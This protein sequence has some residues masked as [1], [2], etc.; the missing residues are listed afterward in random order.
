MATTLENIIIRDWYMDT[1]PNDDLGEDLYE[2][3]T[4][5][6]ALD[7]LENGENFYLFLGVCDSTVLERVFEKLSEL[8]GKGYN[9]IYNMWL[10]ERG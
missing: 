7:T 4:M 5:A 10:K 8:T 1:Y 2:E 6:D 9:E 3:Q